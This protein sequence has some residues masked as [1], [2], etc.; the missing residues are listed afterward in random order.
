MPRA[1][2]DTVTVGDLSG[3]G[4]RDFDLARLLLTVGRWADD[5]GRTLRVTA[6]ERR[7][8]SYAR[9][10]FTQVGSDRL[11]RTVLERAP[12]PKLRSPANTN[13]EPTRNT[14]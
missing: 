2:R 4:G 1:D 10:G 13:T 11:G 6:F 5:T 7:G 8:A 12:R 3:T 14:S 9:L